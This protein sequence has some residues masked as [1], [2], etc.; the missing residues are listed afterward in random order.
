MR[1]L[2][3]ITDL[4]NVSLSK[5]QEI[6][7]DSEEQRSLARCSPCTSQFQI[8]YKTTVI[9]TEQNWGMERET[10]GAEKRAQK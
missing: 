5:F 10:N 6:M 4:M 9:K 8:Y 2:N 1:W 7:K 3:G